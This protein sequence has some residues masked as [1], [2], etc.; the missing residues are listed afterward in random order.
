[1]KRRNRITAVIL[2]AAA[3]VC[4]A[5][6]ARAREVSTVVRFDKPL[7]LRG[8]PGSRYVEIEI[9]VPDEP[10]PSGRPPLNIALVIDRSGS[11]A[12]AGKIEHVRRTA[13]DLVSRLR[14]GDIFS[15]VTYSDYARVVVGP[16]EAS[17]PAGFVDAIRGIYPEGSTNLGEGLT[18]GYAQVR[19]NR[20]PGS[21]NRVL[22]LTDGLA[23]RGVTDARRL[24]EIA[25]A[26]SEEG[27]SL[28]TFGVGLDYNEDLLTAL[29]DGGRGNYWY[30]A[31]AAE[32][33]SMLAREMGAATRA[34]CLDVTVIIEPG[35]GCRV[36]RIIGYPF[37]RE[38]GRIVVHLGDL[39]AGSRKRLMG[40]LEHGAA[41]EGRLGLGSMELSW[42]VPGQGAAQRKR[43]PLGL[44]VVGDAG[45]VE[46]A[47][48]KTVAGRAAGAL[49][50][51]EMSRAASLAD[52]RRY[53]EAN[54]ALGAARRVLEASPVQDA[55]VQERLR[56]VDGYG[57][58]LE[59][60]PSMS[61]P[62]MKEVQKKTKF[63]LYQSR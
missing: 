20:R 55:A 62:A 31:E 60:A 38:D 48:D 49:A 9:D 39:P 30:I 4:L 10:A 8:E 29:A 42:R 54:R 47:A 56:A 37:S 46:K 41:R 26:E 12:A 7:I 16:T 28:S 2:A 14:E 59:N 58:T 1:M 61:A 44:D 50:G 36:D 22:L 40:L 13:L 43:L 45:K 52:E 32:I 35:P 63:D 17:Y 5:G 11:M 34:A 27:I 23:N 19:R 25:A 21:V 53:E 3:V 24:S 18:L 15:L 33:P 51:E 57:K 6:T